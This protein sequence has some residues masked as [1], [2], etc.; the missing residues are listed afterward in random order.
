M[1]RGGPSGWLVGPNTLGLS[2]VPE[3]KGKGKTFGKHKVGQAKH[4]TCFDCE[5][6]SVHW[7]MSKVL[8]AKDVL[9]ANKV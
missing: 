5:L 9:E 3:G 2:E 1:D 7:L 6:K 8:E 4:G